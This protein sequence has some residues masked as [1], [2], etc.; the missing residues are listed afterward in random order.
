[1]NAPLDIKPAPRM[2]YGP[3]VDQ[4]FPGLLGKERDLRCSIMLMRDQ[5]RA[6]MNHCREEAYPVLEHVSH[7]ANRYALEP[8]PVPALE[9]LRYQLLRLI[10]CASGLQSFDRPPDAAEEPDACA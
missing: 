3:M 6:V 4:F 1:M 8:M 2:R 5:A 7:L 9:A 10:S